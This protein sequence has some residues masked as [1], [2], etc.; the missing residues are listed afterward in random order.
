MVSSIYST[1]PTTRF[2]FLSHPFDYVIVS[3]LLSV[4]VRRSD[5]RTKKSVRRSVLFV[6]VGPIL[7]R[8]HLDPSTRCVPPFVLRGIRDD[9]HGPPYKLSPH[10]VPSSWSVGS[11]MLPSWYL[12]VSF[13]WNCC[14][15]SGNSVCALPAILM[16]SALWFTPCSTC[17]DIELMLSL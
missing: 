10:T 4:V 7:L 5:C 15:S 17:G 12:T 16:Y 8:S 9:C 2:V 11:V 14:S 3:L 1:R 13:L 6:V